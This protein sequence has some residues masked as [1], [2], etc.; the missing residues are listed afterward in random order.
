MAHPKP[1]LTGIPLV[2][3]F[4]TR[5]MSLFAEGPLTTLLLQSDAFQ[6]QRAASLAN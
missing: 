4:R 3:S 2:M 5:P 1:R 6:F